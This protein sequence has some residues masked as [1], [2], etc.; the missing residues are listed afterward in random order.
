[1]ARFRDPELFRDDLIADYFQ[2]LAP[3]G[4]TAL[5]WALSRAIDPAQASKLLPPLLG[6]A[7]ALFTFL[8]TRQLH[9]SPTGAFLASVLLSWYLWQ[10]DDL[11]SATPRAF[12]AP[13]LAAQVWALLSG[14]SLLGAVLVGLSPLFYPVA[15]VLGLALLGARLIRLRR[16]RLTLARQRSAWV[17][18]LVAA[19]LVAA[20]LLPE[21]L[22][23]LRFGPQYGLDRMREMPEFGPYGRVPFF[24]ADAYDY[25]AESHLSGLDLRLT[26][27]PLG[28]LPVLFEYLILAALLPALLLFR[29]SAGADRLGIRAEIL[30]QLLL[31]SV[32][33]FFLAHLLLPGLYLPSRYVKWSLP[34]VLSVAGGLALA[35]LIQAIAARVGR[36]LGARRPVGGGLALGLAAA[37]ALYPAQFDPDFVHDRHPA[38]TAYLREQPKDILIVGVPSQADVV[39]SF[40]QRRVL[41]SREHAVPHQ[42]GYYERM[43]RRLD[44]L[45]DAYYA[46]SAEQA[47]DFAARYGVDVFLVDRSAFNRA[48]FAEAWTGYPRGR[49]EPFTSA[50]AAKLERSTAFGLLESIPRCAVIDDGQVAVV[51]TTCLR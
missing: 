12:Q 16:W 46:P 30:L 31:V 48:T 10:Y 19:V 14:R 33:L 44:D 17:A 1:M 38:V 2:S 45:I 13:L 22:I 8:L 41:V 32:G 20:V 3:A 40:T 28:H 4:Y 5:Y 21:Q 50:I 29:R 47:A 37:L 36:G 27:P 15:G 43:R 25:W 6:L 24:V 7:T 49:W 51:P 42:P 18:F 34:L 23:G 35:I 26:H 39:P 11:A 9:P